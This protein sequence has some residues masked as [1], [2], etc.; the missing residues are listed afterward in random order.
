MT[1]CETCRLIQN[2][3]SDE[4]ALW[5][6]ILRSENFDVAHAFNTSLHGWIVVIT[7]RHILAIDELTKDEAMELGTLL[8]KV[9]LGLKK[10]V[11]CSK[12]YVMQFAEQAGHSHVHFHVVPRMP[13]L[14][15]QY[16]GVNIFSYL[17]VTREHRV[18]E[19]IMNNIASKLQIEI[20]H[21]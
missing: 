16:K 11:G 5:D 15:D 7:K 13:D 6:R 2:R 9:S 1:N 18:S 17:G 10:A 20:S 19:S 21:T 14:P 4:A 8:Q 12:T 3:S